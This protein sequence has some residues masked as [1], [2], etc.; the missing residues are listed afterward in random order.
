MKLVQCK[1][2]NKIRALMD[3]ISLSFIKIWRRVMLLGSWLYFL[4]FLGFVY[5][6]GTEVELLMTCRERLNIQD[7]IVQGK[8]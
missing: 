2:A 1:H 6:K 7:K 8:D 4:I 5:I 3:K